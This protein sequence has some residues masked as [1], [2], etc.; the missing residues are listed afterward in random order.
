MCNPALIGLGLMAVGTATTYMGQ[1]KGARAAR[2]VARG[3][4]EYQRKLRMKSLKDASETAD[5]SSPQALAASIAAPQATLGAEQGS[6]EAIAKA[7]M[8]TG[9]PSAVGGEI[10]DAAQA[11]ARRATGPMATRQGFSQGIE[12]QGL[13]LANLAQNNLFLN[14]DSRRS[15]STLQS[16]LARA[17][18]RGSGLRLVGQLANT[19]GGGALSYGLY[20]PAAGKKPTETTGLGRTSRGVGIAGRQPEF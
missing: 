15:L 3:E 14:E 8:Q 20:G 6:A 19:A 9:D 2:K 4:E 1:Q 13:N 12:D 16:R 18:R 5:K 17:G 11:D 10:Y 7:A